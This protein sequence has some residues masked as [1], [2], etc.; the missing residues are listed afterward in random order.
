MEIKGQKDS[1]L[2]NKVTGID[3]DGDEND[4]EDDDG[5]IEIMD[6]K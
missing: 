6:D 2:I 5:D 3:G 4:G 1:N